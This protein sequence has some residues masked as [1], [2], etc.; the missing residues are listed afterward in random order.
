VAASG[1]FFATR[2]SARRI[3]TE[4]VASLPPGEPL[5]LDW[6][7]V[8]AV[9]G[10]FASELATWIDGTSREVGCQGM[11]DEVREAW[12]TAVLRLAG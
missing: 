9:T 5:V 8:E 4:R 12:E 11:N 10:A 3:F 2:D 7:G 1:R 6:T